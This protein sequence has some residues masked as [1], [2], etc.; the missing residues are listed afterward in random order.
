MIECQ[1]QAFIYLLTDEEPAYQNK[2]NYNLI[3]TPLAVIVLNIQ[4]KSLCC[5]MTAFDL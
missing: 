1:H 4:D 2:C 5:Q 3:V